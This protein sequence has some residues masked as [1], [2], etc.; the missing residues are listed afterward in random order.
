ML[1]KSLV[2]A[3]ALLLGTSAFAETTVTA[4]TPGHRMQSATVSV[5]PGASEY[6]PE[7]KQHMLGILR[8][9]KANL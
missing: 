4:K 8:V 5:A 1:I 3:S 9:E 7:G 2:T 6:A